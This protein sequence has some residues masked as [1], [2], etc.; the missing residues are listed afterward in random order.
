MSK[1]IQVSMYAGGRVWVGVRRYE[2]VCIIVRM[3]VG[4]WDE[5]S[6]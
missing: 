2:R 5:F 3:C 1:H 4:V 6:E